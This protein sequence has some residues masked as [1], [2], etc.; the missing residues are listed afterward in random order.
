MIDGSAQ[1]HHQ[2]W[3]PTA[4]SA[5]ALA[6]ACL[7]DLLLYVVLPIHAAAFGVSLVWVGVLLAA[8]RLVRIVLYGGVAALGEAL[9][10]RTLAI[11]A[12]VTAM[13]STLMYG[14]VSGGPALLVARVLWG[15]SFA[16]LNLAALSYAVADR[17]RAGRR[18]GVSRAIYQMGPALT[19]SAGAWL[20]GVV[21]PRDVFLVLGLMSVLAIPFALS[22]PA[23]GGRQERRKTRWLPKPH[24]IDLFFFVV[25][26]AVDGVF[27]MTIVL[28]LAQTATA[29]TAMLS[30]GLI[31]AVR[32]FGEVIFAPIGGVLGDR[33]GATR[34]LIGAALLT[35]AGF[36]ILYAGWA[37][38]GSVVIIIARAVIAAVGPALVARR[39]QQV[40][41]LHRLAVMQTWRDFGAAMGP[42][43]TGLWLSWT[44]LEVINGWLVL[45][46]ILGLATFWQPAAGRNTPPAERQD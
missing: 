11:A 41:T 27:A 12:T 31:L 9:G 35:G 24:R 26:F 40:D 32:R 19:L 23:E 22:L 15:L 45:I 37:Y 25:G 6:L 13:V 44:S 33:Y 30:A 3:G 46:V 18:V 5:A 7:G 1:A 28:V 21:G 8:N 10:P 36:V 34:I 16:A 42:L 14:I 29:E 2:R 39:S 43:V 20:A 4:C 38:V 17:A